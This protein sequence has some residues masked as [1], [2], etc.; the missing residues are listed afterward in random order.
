MTTPADVR[1]FNLVTAA[2]NDLRDDE[3]SDVLKQWSYTIEAKRAAI[4]TLLVGEATECLRL[5]AGDTQD[6]FAK[7]ELL[8]KAEGFL[9]AARLVRHAL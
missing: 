7:T 6:L 9:D 2:A 5:A 3:D 4:W 1:R 8:G